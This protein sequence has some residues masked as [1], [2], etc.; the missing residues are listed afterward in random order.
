MIG[1]GLGF[2]TVIHETVL[3]DCYKKIY[4]NIC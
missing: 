1:A 3:L 4:N 2:A